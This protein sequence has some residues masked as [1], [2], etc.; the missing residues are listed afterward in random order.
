MKLKISVLLLLF[1]TALS[2]CAA[3]GGNKQRDSVSFISLRESLPTFSLQTKI[4]AELREYLVYYQL[5]V[6]P[7]K[8]WFG[9]V[10]SGSWFCPVHLFLPQ[11][12]PKGTVFIIHGFL[13][14]FAFFKDL[15]Q[16]LIDDG[17][18]VAGIDLPGHGLAT[19][20]PTAIDDFS[21]Y[22]QAVADLIKA[23]SPYAP[24][25]WVVTGHSMGCAA[26]LEYAAHESSAFEEY[27]FIAPLLHS[28]L[29]GL[30]R[31]GFYLA[32]PFI[33]SIPRSYQK[34]SSN[35]EYLDF[36]EF[37]DPLQVDQISPSWAEALYTWNTRIY[38]K[39][40]PDIRVYIFQGTLDRV[41]DYR[42]NIRYFSE[43]LSPLNVEYIEGARHELPREI[44]RYQDLLFT[45]I[46]DK[47]NVISETSK[48]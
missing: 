10:Q 31:A 45:S 44:P 18:A 13:S 35:Q 17:W 21:S 42:D 36:K 48:E 41:V 19:G 2:S 7:G 33:D 39:K 25:P 37:H 3:L 26:L 20:T 4:P 32:R 8:Y 46:T 30:S 24:G 43:Y 23:V 27:Y 28:R 15:I 38:Q 12:T 9:Y 1:L 29:Y 6:L 34:T 40:L 47:L 16:L 11:E 14:H 5:P 22:G